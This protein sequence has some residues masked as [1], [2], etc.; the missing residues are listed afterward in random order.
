MPTRS[1]VLRTAFTATILAA[2]LA[3]CGMMG[4]SSGG[5]ETYRATLSGAQEVPPVT[6]SGTGT[7]EVK[8]DS[9]NN[10]LSWK[11]SYSGLSGPASAGHIHGPAGPGQ[12]A[13]V[14]IPFNSVTTQPIT[15]QA[16]VTP[17]QVE[18]LKAGRLY[19][20]LHTPSHPGGEIRGQ[21]EK[22]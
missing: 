4:M 14:M 5:G 12:N 10:T 18:A 20:N 1:Y 8:L 13:G 22:Q 3:G 21:L 2:A 9:A 16:S 11:V 19:V 17:Q 7:A 6:T 15:G